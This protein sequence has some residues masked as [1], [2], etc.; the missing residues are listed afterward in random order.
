MA[1]QQEAQWCSLVGQIDWNLYE[2]SYLGI[3]IYA[4]HIPGNSSVCSLVIAVRLKIQNMWA[5]VKDL[6][7]LSGDKPHKYSSAFLMCNIVMC[8]ISPSNDINEALIA[9]LS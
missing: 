3:R 4:S 8:T 7:S 2:I 1:E 5:E 6:Y 9:Q